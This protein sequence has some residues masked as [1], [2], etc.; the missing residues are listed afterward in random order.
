MAD[1]YEILGVARD[2]STAE[3][4]QA[5]CAVAREKHPDRFADPV[6]EGA[7]PGVLQGR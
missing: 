6:R 1:H 7:G 2:A 3:I 4:R 5:Y